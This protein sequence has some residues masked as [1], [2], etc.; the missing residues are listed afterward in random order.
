MEFVEPGVLLSAVAHGSA[1]TSDAPPPIARRPT[2]PAIAPPCCVSSRATRSWG[3]SHWRW[4]WRRC[5][6]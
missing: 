3:R 6:G 1:T 2:L 4:R 5:S